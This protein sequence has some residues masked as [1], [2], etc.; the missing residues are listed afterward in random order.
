MRKG[1]FQISINPNKE[2]G[3][4]RLHEAVR[5][6]YQQ[7]EPYREYRKEALYEFTGRNYGVK[8][9][10]KSIPVPLVKLWATILIPRLVSRAPTPRISSRYP[11]LKFAAWKLSQATQD[12]ARRL[13]LAATLQAVTKDALFSPMGIIKIGYEPSPEVIEMDGE[14]ITYGDLFVQ[15]VSFNDYIVDMH[16]GDYAKRRYEGNQYR[17]SV[18]DALE[19]GLYKKA[20]DR[21]VSDDYSLSNPD[22]G[23]ERAIALGIDGPPPEDAEDYVTL[24]DIYLPKEKLI[25]TYIANADPK[26]IRV[27]EWDGCEEG[28]YRTL[29][30]D[31]VPD[32]VMPLPP[33][34]SLIDLHRYIND[35]KRKTIRQTNRSKQLLLIKNATKDEAASV[36]TSEDGSG[37]GVGPKC[38]PVEIEFGGPSGELLAAL[39]GDRNLFSWAA[40]N[41]DS[42][43][44]LSPQAD[45]ATQDRLLSAASS[46]PVE[47]M[48]QVVGEF[49]KNVMRS[50][51]E[52]IW[53]DPTEI[54]QLEYSTPELPD[55]SV[56]VEF[57]PEDRSEEF[58]RFNFDIDLYS[59]Q[60]QTPEQQYRA[61]LDWLNAM[62]P[63]LPIGEQQGVSLDVGAIIRHTAELAQLKEVRS[64]VKFMI[65]QQGGPKNA[66]EGAP[67]K[68]AK[69]ERT[70]NHRKVPMVSNE[71]NAKVMQQ[72]FAGMAGGKGIQ[73]KQM[74]QVMGGP[75]Q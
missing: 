24:R 39:E 45:T 6:S 27:Q 17:V 15:Q 62:S 19:S 42:L 21:L 47:Y 49:A 51:A 54:Y 23:D 4:K 69:T 66:N 20:E 63:L 50:A 13:Q 56:P 61:T 11:Q 10:K 71:G 12:A 16:C 64:F 38:E 65:P 73:P 33:V 74:S 34:A 57:A 9:R 67:S 70:Y 22:A 68:P 3:A 1:V 7:M 59:M 46:V 25:V 35:T 14:P 18:Q 48:Q 72:T 26:P 8:G 32:Q 58:F 40:G 30:F 44:G 37:L 2:R 52:Y 55:I 53:Q 43:G 75:K 31:L 29:Q 60:N 28:P 36:L 5:W 41:M